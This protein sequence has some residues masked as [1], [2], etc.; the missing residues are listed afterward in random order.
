MSEMIRQLCDSTDIKSFEYDP[1]TKELRV[2][3]K[4]SSWRYLDVPERIVRQFQKADSFGKFFFKK[5]KGQYVGA[6]IK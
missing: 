5:I 1:D 4:T 6:L 2:T 3:F